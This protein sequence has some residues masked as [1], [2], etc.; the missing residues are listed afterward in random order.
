MHFHK[1]FRSWNKVER[2]MRAAGYSEA[3]IQ[4]AKESYYQGINLFRHILQRMREGGETIKDE[5][6]GIVKDKQDV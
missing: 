4:K 5:P 3:G 6:L 1:E 2:D